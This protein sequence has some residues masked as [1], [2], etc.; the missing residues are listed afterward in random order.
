[1][2]KSILYCALILIP[3]IGWW[4]CVFDFPDFKGLIAFIK[5]VQINKKIELGQLLTV[6][7]QLSAI[8]A[9]AYFLNK[10]LNADLKRKEMLSGYF[11]EA[12]EK[13]AVLNDRVRENAKNPTEIE[14]QYIYRKLHTLS[15]FISLIDETC[16]DPKVRKLFYSV[17]ESS[18]YDLMNYWQLA[19]ESDPDRIDVTLDVEDELNLFYDEIQSNLTAWQLGL[20]FRA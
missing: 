14:T 5:S 11:G 6:F 3:L 16:N 8:T 1:M 15:Q 10:K 12:K 20:F 19:T 13:L 18:I 2:P 17:P 4:I 7:L 9:I